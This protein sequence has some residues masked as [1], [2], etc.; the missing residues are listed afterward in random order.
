MLRI[1]FLLTSLCR[2]VI[3]RSRIGNEKTSYKRYIKNENDFVH[4]LYK[5]F[6]KA[7]EHSFN[8][9]IYYINIYQYKQAGG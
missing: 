3:I 8:I 9:N 4:S 7:K 2:N 5:M 6:F 1:K